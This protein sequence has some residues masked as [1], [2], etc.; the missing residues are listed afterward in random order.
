M[1]TKTT[2]LEKINCLKVIPSLLP[3]LILLFLPEIFEAQGES[4]MPTKL[5][6]GRIIH[7]L[8]FCFTQYFSALSMF[9]YV[10]RLLKNAMYVALL[11]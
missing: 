6:S 11:F 1:A 4:Q 9:F 3:E 5:D 8:A 7:L 10:Y 2:S